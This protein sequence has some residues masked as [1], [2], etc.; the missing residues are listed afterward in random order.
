MTAQPEALRLANE[1][2]WW[3]ARGL[4]LEP[5]LADA[6]EELRRLHESN[7]KLLAALKEFVEWI[8]QG[9]VDDSFLANAQ[10][11]IALAERATQ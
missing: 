9:D 1:F 3:V 5:R 4:N 10:A 6:A 11:A 7:T 2:D 8:E